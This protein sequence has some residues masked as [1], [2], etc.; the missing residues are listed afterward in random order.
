MPNKSDYAAR[1]EYSEHS[2]HKGQQV[3]SGFAFDL[4]NAIL[5]TLAVAFAVLKFGGLIWAIW[6]AFN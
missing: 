5:T 4:E 2:A 3:T 1:L 6:Q